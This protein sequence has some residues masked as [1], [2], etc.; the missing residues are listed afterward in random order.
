MD[1][2]IWK[3]RPP[4]T[5]GGERKRVRTHGSGFIVDETGLIVTNRHVV[6]DAVEI[7]VVFDG[8]ERATAK[9]IAVAPMVDLAGP[10]G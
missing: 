5:P 10:E 4:T 2:A 9:L 6:D 8:G 1:L 7:T 3:E